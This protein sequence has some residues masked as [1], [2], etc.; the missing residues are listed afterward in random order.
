MKIMNCETCNYKK[1]K[2]KLYTGAIEI[3][4]DCG[5]VFLVNTEEYSMDEVLPWYEKLCEV[6]PDNNLAIFPADMVRGI[7][8]TSN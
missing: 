8:L 3:K 6:F 4:P 7:D 1:S 5:Y 2:E